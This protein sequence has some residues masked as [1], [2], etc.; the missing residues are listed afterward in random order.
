MSLSWGTTPLF[1]FLMLFSVVL[2]SGCRTSRQI[3]AEGATLHL[4][5]A[6]SSIK[7]EK[8]P[9]ALKELL[10]AEGLDSKNPLI[11]SSLGLVYFMREKYDLSEKHYLNALKLSPQFTDAKNN[12]ARSYIELNK[13]SQAD[14]LLKEVLA[15]LTYP[16][17]YKAYANFGILEFKRKNYTQAIN[18]LKKSLEK[19]RS[20]CFTHVYLGRSY[21]ENQD[22]TPAVNQLNKAVSFCQQIDSDEA[23][24]F[25][26]I[27]LYRSD[28][29]AQ[30][31]AKFE[32]LIKLFPQ[33]YN[34]DKAQRML[35][36]I[37]KE[38]P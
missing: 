26:A 7:N 2:L 37:T 33:G 21:L 14:I 38:N 25:L 36:I 20:N 19:D 28:Q 17:F 32:E 29:K 9:A 8:Y 18:F 30:A 6:N 31:K 24:Y 4:R 23:H 3:D 35:D 13:L 11:Q 16:E 10:I 27:A 15:D 12:L 22:M 34:L 1:K 5:I